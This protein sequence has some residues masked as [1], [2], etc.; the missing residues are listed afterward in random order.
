M[1]HTYCV[2]KQTEWEYYK[3]KGLEGSLTDSKRE[4]LMKSH[5]NQKHFLE[6]IGNEFD[7][8]GKH[9][10]YVNDSMVD[11]ISLASDGDVIISCGGDGT[12]LSC[13]QN[14]PQLK[15]GENI[16]LWGM[17]SDYN[18]KQGLG[19]HGALTST[20]KKNFKEHIDKFCGSNVV[21]KKP[22]RKLGV[23]VNGESLSPDRGAINDI[24]I[25]HRNSFKTSE[26]KIKQSGLTESFQCSGLLIS[27]G[28]GSRAW[29]YNAG[30]TPFPDGDAFAF[31]VLCPN[32][33][34]SLKFTSGLLDVRSDMKPLVVIPERDDYILAFDSKYDTVSLNVGDKVEFYLRYENHVGI[35]SF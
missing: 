19:S 9:I 17:N 27:T 29:Y 31:K 13:A 3:L 30:G 1:G 34:H 23:R 10:L 16:S 5:D 26:L 7:K 28:L 11:D 2:V 15:F 25:G 35:L 33:K 21:L 20:N 4:E 6:S 24:Y 22:L 8:H 12:F 18:P 14:L 32:L